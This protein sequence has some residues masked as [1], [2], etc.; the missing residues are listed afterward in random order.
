M[1]SVSKLQYL[2]FIQ[3][4]KI[5]LD[6]ERIYHDKPKTIKS[7]GDY[8]QRLSSFFKQGPLRDIHIGHIRQY[9]IEHKGKYVARSINSDISL[10]SRIMRRAGL[11][12][13]IKPHYKP[14]PVPKWT[15]PRV[16]TEAEENHLFDVAATN[17]DY[18]LAYWVGSLSCNTSATGVELRLLQ[19]KHIDMEAIPPILYVPSDRVKNE[20]RARVIPL[21]ERGAIQMQRI[22]DRAESLGSTEPDNCLFPKRLNRAI[23]D[24]TKPAS[25]SFLRKQWKRMREE[26]GFPWLRPHDMRHQIITKLLENGVPEQ[27]VMS[28]AGHVSKEMLELYSHQR[29]DAKFRAL[30]VVNPTRKAVQNGT[31]GGK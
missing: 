11:W 17:P 2:S 14:L 21:N 24:P 15:P 7:Y 3:A 27:T 29:V 13:K 28:I 12:D 22:L 26:A 30:S 4:A 23:Y 19:L 5:W 25:E 10:L 6:E 31:G 8:I 20:Y 1:E 9:Q 18:S 16:L